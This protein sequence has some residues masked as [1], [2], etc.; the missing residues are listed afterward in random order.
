LEATPKDATH[1]STRSM[2][3]EVGLTRSA[4]HGIWRAFGL[5]PHRTETSK[6]SRDPQ[7]VAKVRDVVGLYQIIG[8]LHSRH[9]AIE[10][11][12]FL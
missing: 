4:V 7:F 12:Q 10:F 11:K 9:R 2:A 3:A 1:W 5:Q 8:S 6:V